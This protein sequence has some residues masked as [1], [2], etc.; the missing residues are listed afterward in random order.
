MGQD[1]LGKSLSLRNRGRMGR[2]DSTAGRPA[3]SSVRISGPR[4]DVSMN[5]FNHQMYYGKP[6]KECL[7]T[8][9]LFEAENELNAMS[10]P[11]WKTMSM[12]MDSGAAESVAPIELAPWIPIL[13][14]AGSRRRQTYLCTSGGKLPN[15][16]MK[17]LERSNRRKQTGEGHFPSGS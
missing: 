2:E 3:W 4:R 1:R 11:T 10:E 13:E 5:D 9:G 14:S 8:V 17:A 15:L 7:R 12:V 6:K 16:G